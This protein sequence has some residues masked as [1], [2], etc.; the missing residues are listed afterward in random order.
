MMSLLPVEPAYDPT[1]PQSET[2][3][4]IEF[5]NANEES[6]DRTLLEM[7]RRQYVADQIKPFDPFFPGYSLPRMLSGATVLELG[8]FCGGSSVSF[9][10]RWNVKTVYGLDVNKHFIRAAVLFSSSRQNKSVNYDFAVGRG[11]CLPYDDNLFDAIVSRDTFEHVRSLKD[12]L[13][14]CRRVLRPGGRLFSVFPSYYYPFGG[15]HLS[16]VTNTPFIQWVFDSRILNRAYDDVLES[17]GSE[18]YWYKST[19]PQE[20]D[21]RKLRGGIGINGTT[22]R[23]FRSMV[24]EV[25]FSD[26]MFLPTPLLSVSDV[27]VAHPE[28]KYFCELLKPF[29]RFDVLQDY[30][31]HR[32]VSIMT[33]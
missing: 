3:N 6:K 24:N 28:I 17:R 5:I 27:S 14:E 9:A 2:V 23:E 32:I 12:V 4:R 10:E 21:W 13:I 30:L 31:S 15:A 1:R 18:A 8:C 22:F 11:E 20:N 16:F 29:L 7:A 19:I 25:G 33:K 26:V